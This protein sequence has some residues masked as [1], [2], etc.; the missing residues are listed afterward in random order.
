MTQLTDTNVTAPILAGNSNILNT[1]VTTEESNS[2]AEVTTEEVTSSVT[3]NVTTVTPNVASEVTPKPKIDETIFDDN[4]D[5]TDISGDGHVTNTTS[6]TDAIVLQKKILE[7]AELFRQFV[8][9]PFLLFLLV[10]LVLI[11]ANICY[12]LIY[13]TLHNTLVA[14]GSHYTFRINPFLT[15]IHACVHS[16]CRS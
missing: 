7:V 5:H 11:F 4:T 14:F 16:I 6:D 3:T 10:W 1:N 15:T 2:T 8:L 9:Q 13:T 12:T